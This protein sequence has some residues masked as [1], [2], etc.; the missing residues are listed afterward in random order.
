MRRDGAGRNLLS[1]GEAA[2]GAVIA[3]ACCKSGGGSV[4]KR[5]SVEKVVFSEKKRRFG[6]VGGSLN[7]EATA[8]E[9]V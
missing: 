1:G 9:E 5:K 4:Q 6:G 3:L 2:W 8:L 7:I